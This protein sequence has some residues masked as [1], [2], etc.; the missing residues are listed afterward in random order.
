MVLNVSPANIQAGN[1]PSRWRKR[2]GV[3]Y[4]RELDDHLRYPRDQDKK[5]I[6][7]RVKTYVT[8]VS[9]DGIA[10]YYWETRI[11]TIYPDGLRVI[12]Y[13]RSQTD[14]QRV[15]E[16]AG[17]SIFGRNNPTVT[18][19]NTSQQWT[20]FRGLMIDNN[21]MAMN[22]IDDQ[23]FVEY[24]PTR[25]KLGNKV[26]S[27]VGFLL[28]LSQAER[29]TKRPPDVFLGRARITINRPRVN[30]TGWGGS[31]SYYPTN[32]YVSQIYIKGRVR[33][34]VGYYEDGGLY[35]TSLDRARKW[36]NLIEN[37]IDEDPQTKA[38]YTIHQ[39]KE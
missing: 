16:F 31:Y 35:N 7:N 27:L 29:D 5:N 20:L 1:I 6:R 14:Q 13:A 24:W 3:A 22:P 17:I 9:N 23:E 34:T 2:D 19:H 18:N 10:L 28:A 15:W 36:I 38:A 12:N 30:D 25:A 8:R 37:L 33:A 26:E 4:Y 39:L 11:F 21:G 32:Y